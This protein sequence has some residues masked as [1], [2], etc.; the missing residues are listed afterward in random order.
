MVT[1]VIQNVGKCPVPGFQ[2][3]VLESLR[4]LVGRMGAPIVRFCYDS[5]YRNYDQRKCSFA[6]EKNFSFG[7]T[8]KS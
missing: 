3:A 6:I 4:Y 1:A 5:G 8:K 2:R 7:E